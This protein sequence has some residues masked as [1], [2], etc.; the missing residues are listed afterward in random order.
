MF[1]DELAEFKSGTL[2]VLREPLE[3][4]K[5]HLSRLG[6]SFTYPADFMLVASMNPCP[7]G[8]YPDMNRCTCTPLSIQQ[9]IGRVSQALLNRIDLC[10]EAQEMRYQDM[11]DSGRTESSAEIRKRVER[12]HQTQK[13]RFSGLEYQYNSQMSTEDI[14]KFCPLDEESRIKMAEKYEEYHLSARAYCKVLKT[15]RTIADLEESETVRWKHIEEAL[16]FRNPDKKYW[17]RY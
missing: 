11:I 5:I 6:A 10:V 3:E 16:F 14:E 17:R 9:Y 15:A 4:K 12:V 2:E 13:E 1:L 8:Y 7:C